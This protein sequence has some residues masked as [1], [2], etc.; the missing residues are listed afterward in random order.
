M[1][2]VS[3][4]SIFIL[5]FLITNFALAEDLLTIKAGIDLS[6]DHDISNGKNS[7]SDS[8]DNAISLAAEYVV[9]DD[10]YGFGGGIS[11]Q[12]LRNP[13]G[14]SGDFYFTSIYGL[15]KIGSFSEN[16]KSP[17]F[18]GQLGYNILSGNSDYSSGVSLKGGI[19]YGI[20]FG[21]DLNENFQLETLYS[22]NNGIAES[23]G[24]DI[25]VKYTKLTISVGYNF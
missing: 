24:T 10:D 15:I 11:L 6:G 9:I 3:I 13:E 22:V 18:I 17:Y 2:K 14:W 4:L 1:R 23:S 25:D 16:D 7:R 21:I 5:F 20:G 12:N 19:Y 8:V